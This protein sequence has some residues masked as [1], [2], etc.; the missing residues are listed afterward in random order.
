[1]GNAIGARRLLEPGGNQLKLGLFGLNCSSGNQLSKAETPY[2]ATWEHTL[3]ISQRAD[4]MG[5]EILVPIAR[6][7]GLGGETNPFGTSFETMSWAAGIASKT[8]RIC[9]VGTLHLPMWHPA[10]SAKQAATIDHLSGGRFIFNAVMGWFKP[11]MDMFGIPMREHDRRYDFG[12][13]WMEIVKKMWTEQE[14]FDYDGEFFQMKHVE[15]LPKPLQDPYPV[16]INAGNSGAGMDFAAREADFNFVLIETFEK[17]KEYVDA[18]QGRARE[19]YGREL[20]LLSNAFVICRDSKE[21]ADAVAED[22]LARADWPAAENSMKEFGINSESLSAEFREQFLA[23]WVVGMASHQLI[24]TA[25][26][27]AAGLQ[28]YVDIGCSGVMLSSLDYHGE[29]GIFNEKV[30]P[31]LVEAGLREQVDEIRH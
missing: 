30:M 25:D 7:R 23:K 19:E 6:W 4:D 9:P 12:A 24:G 18:A 11:D 5:F 26:E 3:K 29:L 22:M 17:A 31:L 2:E 1:M 10:A 13:E 28:R 27:V 8:E 20:R 14:P 15:S 21:E 16:V